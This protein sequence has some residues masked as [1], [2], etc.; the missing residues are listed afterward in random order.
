MNQ[1]LSLCFSLLFL[2]NSLSAQDYIEYFNLCNQADKDIY[3]ERYDSALIKLEK[4]FAGVDYVHA[5]N[6]QKASESAMQLQN[7]PQAYQYAK[8]AILNGMS[9]EFWREKTFKALKS[10]EYYP[11]IND[12][13][14]IWREQ[15]LQS[16]HLEYQ[17]LIDSLYYLDQRVIRKNLSVKGDYKI[18]RAIIPENRFD[19]DTSLFKT[20]LMAVER[21]G[22]PSE[23]LVG[24]EAFDKVWVLFH[25]NVRL[26]ENHGYFP[27]LEAAVK[28]G[29]YRPSDFAW[30]YDQ[31]MMFNGEKPKFY[32]GVGLPREMKP[33]L[34]AQIDANRKQMGIKPL[35]SM[36]VTTKGRKTT[37]RFLW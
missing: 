20:L 29:K 23:E 6:Y 7:L 10:S 8:A 26:P 18:D 15:H 35:E 11:F 21:W 31:G 2:T 3:F 1:T 13:L 4:A 9:N 32:Y 36:E 24:F 22:F 19:L 5:E 30:T 27:L 14:P 34:A 16:I 25:H 12:S 28:A 17:S 33:E 37:T